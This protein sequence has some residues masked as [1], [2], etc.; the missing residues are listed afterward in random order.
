[1]R[2]GGELVLDMTLEDGQVSQ[3]AVTVDA[4]IEYR[5]IQQSAGVPGILTA[6]HEWSLEP[7]REGTLVVQREIYRGV[8]VLFYNPAYVEL[9][10][11]QGLKNL[12][13]MLTD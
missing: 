5:S 4:M 7:A 1:M 11:A 8:G 13:A 6:H 10:Y 12:R 2:P 3:I 9:L